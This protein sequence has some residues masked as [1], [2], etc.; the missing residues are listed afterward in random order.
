M[1]QFLGN[2]IVEGN[3]VKNYVGGAAGAEMGVKIRHNPQNLCNYFVQAYGVAP[4]DRTTRPRLATM[5]TNLPYSNITTSPGSHA[6]SE[7]E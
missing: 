2:H 4:F 6:D 3:A 5:T 1:M 7:L